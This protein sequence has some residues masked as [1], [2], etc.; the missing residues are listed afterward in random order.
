MKN[1]IF[2]KGIGNGGVV[3]VDKEGDFRMVGDGREGGR[4]N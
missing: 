4:G 2:R 1:M 3:V